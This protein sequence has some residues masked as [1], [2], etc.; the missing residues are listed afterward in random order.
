MLVAANQAIWWKNLLPDLGDKQDFPT[1]IYYDNK[2][3]TTIAQNPFQHKKTKHIKVNFY[4][5]REFESE[6]LIKILYCAF[7]EQL[8]DV[9][10]KSLPRN[11][12]EVM[13][14]KSGKI[15]AKLKEKC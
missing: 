1:L 4:L 10:P 13:K 12:F 9:L 8:V 7:E 6:G 14:I 2:S 15:E 11:K 3:A 5:A